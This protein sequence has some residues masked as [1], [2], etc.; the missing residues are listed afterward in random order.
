MV[1]KHNNKE[2]EMKDAGDVLLSKIKSSTLEPR[3][4]PVS[5]NN[6]HIII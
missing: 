1:T 5:E 3:F 6:V 2:A 4:L